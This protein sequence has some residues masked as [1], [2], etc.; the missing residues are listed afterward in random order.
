MTTFQS[1]ISWVFILFHYAC[2]L[3]LPK[4]QVISVLSSDLRGFVKNI[5]RARRMLKKTHAEKV[6]SSRPSATT[7]FPKLRTRT[8]RPMPEAQLPKDECAL[9]RSRSNPSL[10]LHLVQLE[11]CR[12]IQ[13]SHRTVCPSIFNSPAAVLWPNTIFGMQSPPLY[14]RRH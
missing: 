8:F 12:L 7:L 4:P 5:G 6:T 14:L 11:G 1:L 3:T 10:S 9:Q 2:C 13:N